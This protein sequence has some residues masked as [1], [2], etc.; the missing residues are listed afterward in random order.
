MAQSPT[1][2][3]EVSWTDTFDRASVPGRATIDTVLGFLED[4]LS[5][6]NLEGFEL[7]GLPVD[8]TVSISA[9]IVSPKRVHTT[10][11]LRPRVAMCRR[12]PFGTPTRAECIPSIVRSA[13][14]PLRLSR[15]CQ[16]LEERMSY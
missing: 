11:V 12:K 16:A 7:P 2:E 6:L 9:K 5:A 13:I 14:R 1:G 4:Q 15:H 10:K 3:S 8:A